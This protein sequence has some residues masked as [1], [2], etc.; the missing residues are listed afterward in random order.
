M[1]IFRQAPEFAA[2][3][4]KH[5]AIIVPYRDR[6]DHLK[7]FVP[8]VI[9]YFQRDK[10]DRHI[11]ISIHVIEQNGSAPFNRGKL[12]NC[13]YML[14]RDV[15]DYVSFHDIDYL[16]IWADY[17][18]SVTPARLIWH[19]LHLGED[20]ENFFGGVVLFDKPAFERVNGY[21]NSYW[22][23]GFEDAELSLRLKLTG[24]AFEKR[25]GTYQPLSHKHAGFSAPGVLTAEGLRTHALY[26]TRR[27]RARQWM[28][29]DGLRSLTFMALR[30]APIAFDGVPSPNAFHYLVDIGAP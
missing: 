9:A 30:K 14:A 8:H 12:L 10:L 20:W 28:A 25:D 29:Q 16:P 11:S 19:G 17:A 23:W 6:A 26:E 15:A 18:W 3:Y 27:S 21:P 7:S 24:L 5:L 4:G 13:G 1:E 2:H 22:G